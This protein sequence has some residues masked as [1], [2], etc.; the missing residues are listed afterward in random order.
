MADGMQLTG[1][2]MGRLSEALRAAFPD[3]DRLDEVLLYH[4]NISRA[5]STLKSNYPARLLDILVDAKA[6]SWT[7]KLIMAGRLSNPEN[8]DLVEFAQSVGIGAVI[9]TIDNGPVARPPSTAS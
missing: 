6:R 4:L 1:P 5:N 7:R 8:P 2:Q 3:P 9:A